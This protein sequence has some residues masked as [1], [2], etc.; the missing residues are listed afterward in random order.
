MNR[1]GPGAGGGRADGKGY[2]QI[3]ILVKL[4]LVNCLSL[5]NFTRNGFS[6]VDHL[7]TQDSPIFPLT[8]G[9]KAGLYVDQGASTIK[10]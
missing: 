5:F 9:G 3:L 8:V 10:V 6:V 2:A 7:W 4:T 1:G